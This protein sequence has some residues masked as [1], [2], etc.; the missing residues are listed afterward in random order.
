MCL[1][2]RMRAQTGRPAPSVQTRR[3]PPRTANPSCVCTSA[4]RTRRAAP[5]TS[6]QV[7]R[8]RQRSPPCRRAD[9]H[10]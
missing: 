2:V 9:A 10:G 4:Q 7:R 6:T 5:C 1:G 8:A 3:G